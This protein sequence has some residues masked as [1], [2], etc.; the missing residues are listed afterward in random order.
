MGTKSRRWR[1]L[2]WN[3]IPY[4]S[5]QVRTLPLIKSEHD[6]LTPMKGR[7]RPARTKEILDVLVNAGQFHANG[8]KQ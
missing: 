5:N 1:L 6:K 8:V 3:G 2:Q 7:P 4:I